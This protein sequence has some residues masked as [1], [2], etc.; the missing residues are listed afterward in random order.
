MKKYSVKVVNPRAVGV[1][2]RADV[3]SEYDNL[4]YD[5]VTKIKEIWATTVYNVV[6]KESE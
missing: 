1:W 3:I 6:I 2:P 5:Q 4:S